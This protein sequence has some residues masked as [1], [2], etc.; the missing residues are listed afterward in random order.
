MPVKFALFHCGKCGSRYNSLLGH[1]CKPRRRTGRVRVKPA[2]R[3]TCSTCGKPGR[4]LTHVCSNRGDFAKR[5]RAAERARKADK[6]KAETAARQAK[7]RA[8]VAEVKTREKAK[9]DKRVAQV[10]ARNKKPARPR[11]P[12]EQHEYQICRDQDCRR[13]A[14]Q[15]YRE[16]HANGYA[17]GASAQD[18]G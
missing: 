15:A 1:V 3:W 12:R 4:P 16:G 13:L 8:R 10:R 9:A 11:A 7:V 6:R 18:G 5:K 17:D 14:C 2:V